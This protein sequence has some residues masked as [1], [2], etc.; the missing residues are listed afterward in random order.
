MLRTQMFLESH[1]TAV[2]CCFLLVS[3]LTLTL[4]EPI[5]ASATITNS[6]GA[7]CDLN[8]V[9]P[10]RNCHRA[11]KTTRALVLVWPVYPLAPQARV[12]GYPHQPGHRTTDL[13]P[14]EALP[15]RGCVHTENHARR[16]MLLNHITAPRLQ[17]CAWPVPTWSPTAGSPPPPSARGGS[18][19]GPGVG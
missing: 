12:R 2:R 18:K 19:V 7:C 4:C 9:P 1:V 16:I 15:M 11:S 6:L 17:A 14:Q 8:M 3:R 13:R 10:R 5:I